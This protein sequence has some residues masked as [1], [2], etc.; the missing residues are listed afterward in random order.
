M[1]QESYWFTMIKLYLEITLYAHHELAAD[2]CSH[3]RL[4]DVGA[5]LGEMAHGMGERK[6]GKT[7]QWFL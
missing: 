3:F 2:L 4:Q 1:T 5:D 7:M 6:N